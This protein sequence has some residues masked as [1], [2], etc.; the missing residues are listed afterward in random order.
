MVMNTVLQDKLINFISRINN[1]KRSAQMYEQ[2]V[3]ILR[4]I[5]AAQETVQAPIAYIS[6]DHL[7]KATDA[8]FLCRVEPT[9]REGMGLIPFYIAA[10]IVPTVP[11]EP[12][13]HQFYSTCSEKWCDFQNED[14]YQD[15]VADGGFKIRA[16]YAAPA[17]KG[18]AL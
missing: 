2:D 9:M 14:H 6:K 5:I 3:V 18:N 11:S 7:Q 17:D 10:P 8:P 15:T 1:D 4:E 12:V 13:S 16:L